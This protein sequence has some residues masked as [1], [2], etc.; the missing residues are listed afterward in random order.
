MYVCIHFTVE[1]YTQDMCTVY[2]YFT[3]E[4][5]KYVCIHMYA[6]IRGMYARKHVC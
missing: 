6:R 3:V 1:Y 5:W 4:Y 2:L